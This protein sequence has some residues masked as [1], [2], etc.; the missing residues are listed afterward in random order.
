[1]KSP[2]T[3]PHTLRET[4]SVKLCDQQSVSAFS[5]KRLEQENKPDNTFSDRT[6]WLVSM[7]IKFVNRSSTHT[8]TKF[9]IHTPRRHTMPQHLSL[10]LSCEYKTTL[11]GA[12]SS[13]VESSRWNV[14]LYIQMAWCH[15]VSHNVSWTN[16]VSHFSIR[17]AALKP[18]SSLYSHSNT[19]APWLQE[20]WTVVCHHGEVPL[21]MKSQGYRGE[22]NQHCGSECFGE[23]DGKH[24]STGGKL[25]SKC[26]SVGFSVLVY[27][28]V[29]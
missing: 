27:R 8:L 7:G 20:K 5:R 16:N 3:H 14:Y 18:P 6:K 21:W 12:L 15:V 28:N 23:S 24:M 11:T 25:L 22:L 9:H 17:P 29:R 4:L 1:M 19:P 2:A 10:S 13:L 26:F